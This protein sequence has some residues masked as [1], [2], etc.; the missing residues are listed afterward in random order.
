MAKGPNRVLCRSIEPGINNWS[1][2]D[3]PS[4]KTDDNHRKHRKA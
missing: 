1:A 3:K 2:I 4:A